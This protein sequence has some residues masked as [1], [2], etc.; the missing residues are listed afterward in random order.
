MLFSIGNIITLGIVL[1]I[2]F[3]YR[4]L[5]RDNRSLEKVKKYA[6]RLRDELSAYVEKRAEDLKRFG[7]DL[8][9]RQKAAKVALEKIQ[10]VEEGLS[11]R[12]EAIGGI[13]KRL[14]EYDAA[15][16]RLQEMTTRVDENLSRLHEESEFTDGL[17]RRIDAAQKTLIA[18]EK[19]IP[20]L[21]QVFAKDA[22]AALEAHKGQIL[23][24]IGRRLS[25]TA[26][27]V[28][29]ARAESAASLHR[30]EAGRAELE[31]ELA[32]GLERARLEAEKLED[33]AFAKLKEGTEAKAARLKELL[34]DK[35]S[36]LAQLAKDK[37]AETQGLVKNFKAEWKAEAEEL[38]A[39]TRKETTELASLT[40]AEVEKTAAALVTRLEE[41]EAR[42]S[43]AELLA[44][45]RYAAIAR[46]SEELA[47]GLAEKAKTSLAAQREEFEKGRLAAEAAYKAAAAEITRAEAS[48][49]ESSARGSREM[50]A[51][52]AKSQA[53]RDAIAAAVQTDH[54][55][56]VTEI[57]GERNA[58]ATSVKAELDALAAKVKADR[59]AV[60]QAIQDSRAVLEARIKAERE[61]MEARVSI[62]GTAASAKA[63]D[64]L[65]RRL[66][67]YASEAEARFERLEAAGA[68]IGALDQALRASMDQ[69]ARSVE[70]DFA[71]FGRG[72]E[73]RRTRFEESFLGEAAKLRTGMKSLEEELDALKARAYDNVSEK[74]KVFEDEFFADLTTRSESVD[75][76]LEAWRLDLD[77]TLSDLAGKTAADRVA[78]EKAQ[79]EELRASLADHQGRIQEQLEKL[80]ERVGAVQDGIQAQSGMAA[81]ALA[82]LKASVL[83][84]ASDARATAQAYVEGEI[85]RFSLESSARIKASE[86]ELGARLESLVGIVSAEEERVASSREAV[87]KAA[88][89]LRARF[90]ESV[91]ETDGTMRGELAA[92]AASASKLI[93]DSRAEYETQR[94]SFARAAQAERDRISKELAGLADRTAELRTD[95][96]GR[97]SQALDGFSRGYESLLVDLEKKKREAAAESETRTRELREAIQALAQQLDADRT[98][99][100]GRI[101]SEAARLGQ[102]LA[103]IDKEQKAFV[104]QTKLF[105]RADELKERL[106][107]NI[108]TM[109]ADLSRLDA[110]KVEVA[111]LESQLGRVKRLE[112]EVNQKVTRF[113][114]EKRRID[115]LEEDFSRLA[116]VSQGV[117]RK[118]EE[119]TGQADALTSAQATIRKL[120]ELGQEAEAKYERLEKKADVLDAT[121]EAVDKNFQSIQGIEKALGSIGAELKRIPERV[122]ELRRSVDELAAGKEKADEAARKLGELDGILADAEKRI[123]EA[124]KAREWLARAE[125]RLEDIDRRA[126]EQLKLLSTLLKEEGPKRERGAPPS[127]VQD[128]VRKLA[129]QGWNVDEIARAVK[130]SRGEVELILELGGKA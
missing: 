13:E 51:L 49:G 98:Q 46:R 21:K 26:G 6:D 76:R 41:A 74:L 48:L 77:R 40:R 84:D 86:R 88:E 5:D 106:A 58:F 33:V 14:A 96:S 34:E 59:D 43:A 94:D 67:E 110:R 73:D 38:L 102:T 11:A 121:A 99:S 85:S 97:I 118:L 122:L 64:D 82:A 80:R 24:E 89:A 45:E 42:L 114:A 113:L 105:E 100:M 7:I 71:A 109:K 52:A 4:Q 3:V 32:K 35:L 29:K 123:A 119:V 83:K 115:A 75:A 36:Q 126:Q 53:E 16:A 129:R 1:V 101:E 17:S 87:T 92:F 103:D 50:A 116:A 30:V 63:F 28:D 37:T 56:L 124:Q 47:A 61:A 125:T 79:G 111:E 9:V 93:E 27:L 2:L 60:A 23:G 108:E 95:L 57:Q 117:D 20:L 55:E 15:L 91:K 128:T 31:R 54:D 39:G 8:D 70:G 107:A 19:E 69:T 130:I 90:A 104:G 127:S 25:E 78:A 44:G 12:A 81:E 72:L 65:G 66:A 62:E 120:L 22:G 10:N 112:D 68:E 18:V